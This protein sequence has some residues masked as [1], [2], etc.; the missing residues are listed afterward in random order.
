MWYRTWDT[1]F[2]ANAPFKCQMK[3]LKTCA[4]LMKSSVQLFK[5]ILPVKN[6]RTV[7]YDINF[8][9]HLVRVAFISYL[10]MKCWKING[11][12]NLSPFAFCTVSDLKYNIMTKLQ[13]YIDGS[14]F[15][16]ASILDAAQ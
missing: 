14:A 8:A 2:N 12:E 10:L 13:T 7:N 11:A 6:R 1:I 16:L 4:V 3:K 9:L 5:R 15:V